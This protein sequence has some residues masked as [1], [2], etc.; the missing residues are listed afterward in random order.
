M[1]KKME[2]LIRTIVLVPYQRRTMITN[3]IVLYLEKTYTHLDVC[4]YHIIN[5]LSIKNIQY[6]KTRCPIKRYS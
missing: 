2:S 3:S 4:F 5:T 1:I 6:L